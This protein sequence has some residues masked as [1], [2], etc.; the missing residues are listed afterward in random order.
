MQS[1]TLSNGAIEAKP[2]V[3]VTIVSLRNLCSNN[4]IAFYDLVMMCRDSSYQVGD[5]SLERLQ[6]TGFI[7][8]TGK[9]HESIVNI[10]TA[11]VKGDGLDMHIEI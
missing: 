6:S 8:S 2:L 4:P 10:V 5:L 7:E 11:V 3:A 9:L 1:V